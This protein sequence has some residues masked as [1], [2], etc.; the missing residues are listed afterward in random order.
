MIDANRLL[1]DLKRLLKTLIQDLREA[2][3][4]SPERAALEGE[5]RAAREA[6]RTGESFTTFLDDAIEQSAVH[7]VLA[8]VFLRFVE[9]N[10]LVERPW[11]AGPGERMH[12]ARD[13]SEAWFRDRPADSDR[14]YLL[15]CF[16][17]AACLPACRAWAAC[18]TIAT[19][20]STACPSRATAAWRCWPFGGRSTRTR[21]G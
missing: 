17:E 5:W 4:G 12:L 6:G 13:R 3:A 9:D 14:E 7:W 8:C 1:A 10:G 20:P 16:G 11:L 19:T 18:S 15:G 2:H 21:A